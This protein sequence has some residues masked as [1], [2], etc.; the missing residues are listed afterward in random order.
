MKEEDKIVALISGAILGVISVVAWILKVEK[1]FF[2]VSAFVIP[3]VI[4][5]SSDFLLQKKLR[6]RYKKQK[7]IQSTPKIFSKVDFTKLLI[8]D[9]EG[10]HEDPEA[11]PSVIKKLE[12][13]KTQEQI[14]NRVKIQSIV[15]YSLF[16]LN[17]IFLLFTLFFLFKIE[18]IILSICIFLIFTFAIVGSL[19]K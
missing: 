16:F 7:K 14:K 5:I 6:Q 13:S 18:A 11:D 15:F 19:K 4:K 17:F 12:E 3:L 1:E 10:F 8:L 2:V 9:Q